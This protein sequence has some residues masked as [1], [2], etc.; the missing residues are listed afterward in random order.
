MSYI[1]CVLDAAS[2]FVHILIYQVH[3]MMFNFTALDVKA[4]VQWVEFS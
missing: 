2:P 1:S 4:N 3:Q